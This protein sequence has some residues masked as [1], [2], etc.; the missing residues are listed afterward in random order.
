MTIEL[1]D[2]H[3]GE[4]HISSEDWTVF[5]TATYGVSGGVF[6][7]GDRFKLAMTTSN[8]GTLGTGACLVD[9]KRVWIK[10]PEAVTI[11]SGGQGVKRNDIV[12]IQYETYGDGLERAVV[13]TIKGTPSASPADP[14]LPARFLA[15]WRVPLDGIT[16]GAPVAMFTALATISELK[17]SI[18]K[19]TSAKHKVLY[20]SDAGTTGDLTLSASVAGYDVVAIFYKTNDNDF[21]STLVY[22]PNGKTVAVGVGVITGTSG[23]GW[24]KSKKYKFS[25]AKMEYTGFAGESSIG[26]HGPG[27]TNYYE[28]IRVTAVIGFKLH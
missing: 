3:T 14:K 6:A 16:V 1:M 12:G 27:G 19:A 8:K 2:G 24:Y 11:E 21:S 4:M 23:A 28:C 7:W 13:K 25:G 15:L 26:G 20:K 10:T 17:S 22:A 9:G 18:A 5:N